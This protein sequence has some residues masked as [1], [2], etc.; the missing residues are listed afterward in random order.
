[1]WAHLKVRVPSVHLRDR[2]G[3][4]LDAE[5]A[6]DQPVELFL[7]G[8]RRP[9]A[10]RRPPCAWGP[11]PSSDSPPSSRTPSGSARRLSPEGRVAAARGRGA[12]ELLQR[13]ALG[14]EGR[15]VHRVERRVQI[16]LRRDALRWSSVRSKALAGLGPR[17]A[18]WWSSSDARPVVLSMQR[19]AAPR[20]SASS[21]CATRD[22][23]LGRRCPAPA[24]AEE[25][26][27]GGSSSVLTPMARSR[28]AAPPSGR[29]AI[30]LPQF[31]SSLLCP[32]PRCLGPTPAR[33]SASASTRFVGRIAT[34]ARGRDANGEAP[35]CERPQNSARAPR[36][37]PATVPVD[38][39]VA[40]SRLWRSRPPSRVAIL[41]RAV[42]RRPSKF[43]AVVA[44]EQP[45]RS[46]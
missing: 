26:T 14:E 28:V 22:P 18:M 39:G 11:S 13:L 44:R 46:R 17:G 24:L 27:S 20:I 38:D 7:S 1:M 29:S 41:A 19:A 23:G 32:G 25:A 9:V 40:C 2:P 30:S 4:R 42:R 34:A 35:G 15:L 37:R 12:L 8:R 21:P 43:R 16:L 33:V 6:V 3:P 10:V 31:F 36:K 45:C 5:A